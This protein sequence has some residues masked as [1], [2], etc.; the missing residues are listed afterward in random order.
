MARDYTCDGSEF[1]CYVGG[2][3]CVYSVEGQGGRTYACALMLKYG[4]WDDVIASPEYKPIGDTWT[5]NGSASPFDYCRSFDPQFCCRPDMR[6]DTHDEWG[7]R[8]V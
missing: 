4:N 5:S 1:C 3:R 7:R 8:Q 6:K 2:E